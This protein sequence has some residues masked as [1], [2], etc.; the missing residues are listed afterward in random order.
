M[1][2]NNNEQKKGPISFNIDHFEVYNFNFNQVCRI[3][4]N[5]VRVRNVKMNK[6]MTK[7]KM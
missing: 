6:I 5:F 1:V 3:P 4:F 7:T 2:L